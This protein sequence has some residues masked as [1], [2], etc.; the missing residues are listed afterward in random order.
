MVKNYITIGFKELLT[1]E[2]IRDIFDKTKDYVEA[3]NSYGTSMSLHL[4]DHN[5]EMTT[6]REDDEADD[7]EEF[8]LDDESEDDIDEDDYADESDI[9]DEEDAYVNKKMIASTEEKNSTVF[10]KY[11]IIN[12]TDGSSEKAF[13]TNPDL[14]DIKVS[15]VLSSIKT[16]VASALYPYA[17]V[18]SWMPHYENEHAM[19]GENMIKYVTPERM[20]KI[21]HK[22][23]EVVN[24]IT[25]FDEND[26]KTL[27]KY[28]KISGTMLRLAQYNKGLLTAINENEICH[29]YNAFSANRVIGFINNIIDEL[30]LP[31][32]VWEYKSKVDNTPGFVVLKYF[33][34]R[35]ATL[36][37]TIYE[38]SLDKVKF[39]HKPGD[40]RYLLNRLSSAI[41]EILPI[42]NDPAIPDEVFVSMINEY[43]KN[44]HFPYAI[45][46][47][48]S[49]NTEMKESEVLGGVIYV[50]D[51]YDVLDVTRHEPDYAYDPFPVQKENNHSD[52]N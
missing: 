20:L 18:Y 14:D 13:F 29:T 45:S 42:P 51:N 41:N 4:G 35:Y 22:I 26:R 3:I 49:I 5:A 40:I 31:Y 19:D 52:N 44:I 34:K 46:I 1:E 37:K 33:D 9:D 24:V 32:I 23:H 43:L 39:R 12:Y 17:M 6:Y 11:S 7:V 2:E 27:S 38:V 28:A 25:T 8:D 47:V 50:K 48:K 15:Q 30:D 10:G 36:E 16:Y 21:A